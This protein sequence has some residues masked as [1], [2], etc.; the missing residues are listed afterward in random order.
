MSSTE[1]PAAWQ[2][3][4]E[5]FHTSTRE[6]AGIAN[7]V[8]PGLLVLYHQ[9][10]WGASDG[11]LVNEIRNAGYNGKVVSARDLDVF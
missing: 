1:R 6:L 8:K 11:D 5:A 3:Y 9:L 2:Y 4:Q 7:Q 10:Y